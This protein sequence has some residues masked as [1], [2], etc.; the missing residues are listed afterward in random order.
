MALLQDLHFCFHYHSLCLPCTTTYSSSAQNACRL[1]SEW[2]NLFLLF[3]YFSMQLDG[4]STY[5]SFIHLLLAFIKIVVFS[6]FRSL[7]GSCPFQLWLTCTS[8]CVSFRLSTAH[9]LSSVV[10]FCHL[11]AGL[12]VLLLCVRCLQFTQI[13]P[14]CRQVSL[15][16]EV[17][18][19]YPGE[20]CDPGGRPGTATD[21]S[22]MAAVADHQLMII[23]RAY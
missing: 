3:S 9:A 18:Q 23:L 11:C 12:P 7:T 19:R 21:V 5:C 6:M 15:L 1:S 4:V 10:T 22:F 13:W 2:L 8:A 14:Y 16:W 17:L 20:Q